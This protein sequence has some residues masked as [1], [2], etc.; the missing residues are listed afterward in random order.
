MLKTGSLRCLVSCSTYPLP[1]APCRLNTGFALLTECLTCKACW[2]YPFPLLNEH[3]KQWSPVER[4]SELKPTNKQTKTKKWTSYLCI[5]WAIKLTFY[6]CIIHML[7]T[8]NMYKCIKSHTEWN[9][10]YKDHSNLQVCL[11]GNRRGGTEMLITFRSRPG[12]SQNNPSSQSPN[13]GLASLV[14]GWHWHSLILRCVGRLIRLP[15]Q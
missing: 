2:V 8:P 3:R 15:H 12:R 7:A 9:L 10:G 1:P 6:L 11:P 4:F 5:P 14:E 13:W